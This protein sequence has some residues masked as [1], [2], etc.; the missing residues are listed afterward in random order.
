MQIIEWRKA[1]RDG[2]TES[3]KCNRREKLRLLTRT[4]AEVLA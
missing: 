4:L 1:R 3:S 2:E